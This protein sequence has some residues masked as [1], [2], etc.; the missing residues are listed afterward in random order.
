[1]DL[2]RSQPRIGFANFV[3]AASIVPINDLKGAKSGRFA[4]KE[5]L[6][7][8]KLASCYRLV[9]LCGWT[10]GIFNHITARIENEGD[11]HFL[12]NPFGLLYNEITAS[13]LHKVDLNGRII[14]QGTSGFGVNKPGF[15]LHSAIYE[16]RS[17]VNFIVHVHTASSVAVSALKCGL[18]PLCQEALNCGGISYH[19]YQGMYIE[20]KAQLVNELGATNKV[21]I[22]KNQGIIACGQTVEEAFFLAFNAV[23][24]C[25]SQVKAA[26]VGLDNLILPDPEI[27]EEHRAR[28]GTDAASRDW[29]TGE[30]E[31]EALM[32]TLDNLGYRTG[33][34]YRLLPMVKSGLLEQ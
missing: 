34:N 31:F 9:D 4:D 33:Y 18:L 22:L 5:Q 17:D 20:D 7:R 23:A 12:V 29:K 32:R 25:E 28:G 3:K 21:L 27:S 8:C 1:M 30:V 11:N 13:S 14:D 16:A 15:V 6:V 10:H 24:A 2:I 26:A 19:E